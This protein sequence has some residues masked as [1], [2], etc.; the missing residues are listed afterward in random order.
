MVKEQRL[1]VKTPKLAIDLFAAYSEE[2]HLQLYITPETMAFLI[3]SPAVQHTLYTPFT[4]STDPL[5]PSITECETTALSSRK[6]FAYLRLPAMR[7]VTA[8]CRRCLAFSCSAITRHGWPELRSG[9]GLLNGHSPAPAGDCHTT[10]IRV[11]VSVLSH[12][13]IV[14]IVSLSSGLAM[15]NTVARLWPRIKRKRAIQSRSKP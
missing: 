7:S 5:G 11:K 1:Q 3:T 4:S 15:T 2:H 9:G 10:Q 8:T 13:A 6:P 12:V 14:P